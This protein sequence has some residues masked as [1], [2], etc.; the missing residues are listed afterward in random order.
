MGKLDPL[1]DKISRPS[2]GGYAK[3]PQEML[4]LLDVHDGLDDEGVPVVVGTVLVTWPNQ[5]RHWKVGIVAPAAL[6]PY[7]S[8]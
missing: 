1:V 3:V 6:S 7:L 4:Y 2:D 8:E 5:R